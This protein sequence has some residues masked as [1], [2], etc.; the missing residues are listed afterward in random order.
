M[1]YHNVGWSI[2]RLK[3][4]QTFA[5]RNPQTLHDAL[6]GFGGQ[7]AMR[8]NSSVIV[9]ARRGLVEKPQ[10]F[11]VTLAPDTN[12]IMQSHPEPRAQ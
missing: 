12:H 8:E 10:L 5:L 2:G 3:S 9:E 6:P 7:T 4:L 11:A 1:R